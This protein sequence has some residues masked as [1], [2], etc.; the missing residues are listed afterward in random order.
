MIMNPETM[1]VGPSELLN[2]KLSFPDGRL[3]GVRRQVLIDRLEKG[4]EFKLTLLSAPA[5]SGKTTLVSAWLAGHMAA[6]EV[7]WVS[8][9]LGDNDPVRFWRYLITACQRFQP[10]L[11][12]TALDMLQSMQ[13][14]FENVLTLW[15]N[16]LAAMKKKGIL[17]L[18]DYHFITTRL[19]HDTVTF[20]L[21]HLPTT[22]HLVMTTR[23][24]PLLP[25]PRLRVRNELSEFHMADLRFSNLEIQQ[26]FEDSITFSLSAETLATL[27]T[28]T[29]GW[30]AGLQLATLALQ[31]KSDVGE[32]LA[33]FTGT[34]Q[35][36]FDYLIEDV[37]N[38]QSESVQTF[39]LETAFLSR[40]N[41]ELCQAVTGRSDSQ[42]MLIHVERANLF[43]SSIGQGWYRYHTLFAEAL[44]HYALTTIDEI[45]LHE[46]RQQASQWYEGHGI[47]NDAI[48]M[49]YEMGDYSRAA[50]LIERFIEPFAGNNEYD[51]L[52]RMIERLPDAFLGQHPKL[53]FTLAIATLFTSDRHTTDTWNLIQKPLRIAEQ[54]WQADGSA[55]ELGEVLSFRSMAVWWQGDLEQSFVAAHHALE[56]LPED[57]IHWRAVSMTNLGFESMLAGRLNEARHLVAQSITFFD[58]V[59]NEYGKR[60]CMIL[61]GE[62]CWR[63][64]ELHYAEQIFRQV[65]E[66]AVEDPSDR[67]FALSALAALD[68]EFGNLDAARALASQSYDLAKAISEPDTQA[69]GAIILAKV[70]HAQGQIT[71]AQQLLSETEALPAL[72]HKALQ[73][74]EVR[75]CRA[76]LALAGGDL[77]AVR[78]WLASCEQEP[79]HLLRIQ[80][81]QEALLT[82]RLLI[83]QRESQEALWLLNQWQVEAR[84]QSRKYV[85]LQ[86]L[87]L[88]SLAYFEQNNRTQAHHVFAKAL[89]LGE[90]EG[91][92]R[93]FL[94]E[95]RMMAD[96]L[97]DML[98]NIRGEALARYARKLLFAFALNGD[99]KDDA[100]IVEPLSLQ[101]K[102]VLRLLSAGLSNPEIANELIVSINTVKTQVKSIYRKLNVSSRDEARN[103]AYHL[104]L[105]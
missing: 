15:I 51:T 104:Q 47:A 63:Q 44:Q 38:A 33:T 29:E 65:L 18:D 8:L 50:V 7:A 83:V 80:Q 49:A 10:G 79:D 101:E 45:R 81:E 85:E 23:H 75:A 68:Y 95:G 100:P 87:I 2:T 77:E 61:L 64:G 28:R 20:L 12:A 54:S 89:K 92:L 39:L 88:K 3:N 103:A 62:I 58:M 98:P 11:G 21:E 74:R 31:G 42:E 72:Q 90:P 55:Q 4:R 35:H 30:A 36:V 43:L 9:D 84:A 46:L 97:K 1:N 96:L 70:L 5:G 102:R 16:E 32:F 94:D 71:Q 99:E 91:F 6:D 14:S 76:T 78:N 67:A 48:E 13:P 24:D 19:I 53:C 93:L 73:L 105:R 26:F 69:R 52:R 34:H 22:L 25:L 27:E 60:A 41:A 59:R 86:I 57:D 66:N 40:L 37:F 82:A 56:L 17:I